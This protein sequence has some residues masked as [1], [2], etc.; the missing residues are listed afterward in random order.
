MNKYEEILALC[1]DK[2]NTGRPWSNGPFQ[3]ADMAMATNGH[4][5][6][7]CGVAWLD[8]PLEVVLDA[9][10]SARVLAVMPKEDQYNGPH[11]I[12]IA[13]IVEG[14]A[15]CPMYDRYKETPCPTCDGDGDV[16]WGFKH[17]TMM[18]QCPVCNGAEREKLPGQEHSDQDN[19]KIGNSTF[20]T[21]YLKL[22][23][24]IAK[25][26]ELDNVVLLYQDQPNKGSVFNF[27]PVMLL[28]MPTLCTDNERVYFK[29]PLR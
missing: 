23:I 29:I 18:A 4:I 25:I 22:L 1:A 27:G 20:S 11:V 12:H 15:K 16:E 6:A 7:W 8:K 17:H 21:T 13:E 10:Q 28:V 9:G 5:L 26:L 24:K 19:G 2:D 3:I 14:L